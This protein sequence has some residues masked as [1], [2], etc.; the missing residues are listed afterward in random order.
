MTDNPKTIIAPAALD[1]ARDRLRKGRHHSAA[2][3]DGIGV[4]PSG[5]LNVVRADDPPFE[6]IV[7]DSETGARRRREAA[8]RAG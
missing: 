4:L 5:E 8:A 1:R 2:F 7:M 3:A 6:P